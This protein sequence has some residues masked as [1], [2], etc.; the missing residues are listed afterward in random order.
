MNTEHIDQPT[1]FPED[2]TVEN[3]VTG[4]SAY[5]ATLHQ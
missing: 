4:S 2:E 5:E 3:I 1:L